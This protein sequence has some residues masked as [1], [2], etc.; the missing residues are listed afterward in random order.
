MS[1]IIALKGRGGIGK[2]TTIW[3][4]HDL[5]QANGFIV[6]QTTRNTAKG[7]HDFISVFTKNGETIGLTSWGDTH[8]LVLNRLTDLVNY[9]CTI[10]VCACRSYDRVNPGTHAAIHS[11]TAFLSVFIDKVIAQNT[12]NELAINTAD[13]T[14]IL[15]E[16]N[17]LI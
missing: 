11:F 17:A 8:D 4:L 6:T 14:K 1:T 10:C 5:M 2:T 16:I 3:L 15:N 13:A 7:I 12:A 9:G